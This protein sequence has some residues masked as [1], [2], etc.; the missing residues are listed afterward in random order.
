MESGRP[1][2]LLLVDDQPEVLG[3]LRTFLRYSFGDVDVLTADTPQKA[4]DILRR[5]R[6]DLVVADFVMPGMDGLEF[7]GEAR[8]LA[9]SVPRVLFTAHCDDTEIAGDRSDVADLVFPKSVALEELAD[10]VVSLLDRP[11]VV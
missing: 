1:R 10:G 4:L 2:R 3:A 11:A 8:R 7:L 9:P 5:E 6:V